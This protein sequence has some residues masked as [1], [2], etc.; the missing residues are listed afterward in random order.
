MVTLAVTMSVATR[1][2]NANFTMTGKCAGVREKKTRWRDASAPH[3]RCFSVRLSGLAV[4]LTHE[5]G[6]RRVNDVKQG[7]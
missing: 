4:H 7:S 1:F 6:A 3:W 2:G 5:K